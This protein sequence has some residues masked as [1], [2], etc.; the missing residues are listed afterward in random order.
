[1]ACSKLFS[2]DLPEMTNYILQH[3]R[4]DSRSLYSCIQVNRL[5]CRIAI[6]LLWED[7]F[8]IPISNNKSI[9]YFLDIYFLY[10]NKDDKNTL[11]D[12]GIDRIVSLSLKSPL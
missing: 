2:G 9:V 11:K 12:Y 10:L 3:L 6:P 7:P 4:N 8:S 1:M 5:F